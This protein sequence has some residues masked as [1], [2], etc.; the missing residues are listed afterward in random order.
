MNWLNEQNVQV[1]SSAE[2][3]FG[4]STLTVESFSWIGVR[5]SHS[6]HNQFEMFMEIKV[7][8]LMQT[9]SL[10]YFLSLSPPRNLY[11]ACSLSLLSFLRLHEQSNAKISNHKGYKYLILCRIQCSD[12]KK[13][14]FHFFFNPNRHSILFSTVHAR[15]L[16][17]LLYFGYW[18]HPKITASAKNYKNRT[19]RLCNTSVCTLFGDFSLAA[20]CYCF[21]YRCRHWTHKRHT[22]TTHTSVESQRV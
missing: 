7:L 12:K 16:L 22:H 4:V 10:R 21:I 13:L 1:N 11:Y 2:I 14:P 8:R 15:L 19:R 20:H 5:S 9:I 17:L 3:I 18:R 6:S